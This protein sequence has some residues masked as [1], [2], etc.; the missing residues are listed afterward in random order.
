MPKPDPWLPR[1]GLFSRF[2]PLLAAALV[3]SWISF[4][5]ATGQGRGG[6]LPGEKVVLDS[7]LHLSVISINDR[8][9]VMDR[10]DWITVHLKNECKETRRH[11]LVE[12]ILLDPLGNGIPSRLWVLKRGERLRP[13]GSKTENFPVP[14]PDNLMASRWS[15][16]LIY[17]EA[18]RLPGSKR[19]SAG[20]RRRTRAR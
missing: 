5:P 7:C 18:Q 16:R 13:G 6:L 11:L 20:P 17:V 2:P 10:F 14:D 15:A 1:A 19:K 9:G 4:T 12:L 3:L 8:D